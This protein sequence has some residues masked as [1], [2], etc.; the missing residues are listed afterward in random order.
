MRVL[1][2][3]HPMASDA[4]TNSPD[5]M[6][7]V[8]ELAPSAFSPSADYISEIVESVWREA[9]EVRAHRRFSGCETDFYRSTTNDAA[10]MRGKSRT[11][12]T[13]VAL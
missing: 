13:L 1:C 5:D 2:T 4:T 12:S 11:M 7:V 8:V 3:R 6:K 10:T 9:T